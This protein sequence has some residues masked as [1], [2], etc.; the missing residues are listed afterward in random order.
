MRHYM[1]PATFTGA[2]AVMTV[3]MGG[4]STEAR[5]I[6]ASGPPDGSPAAAKPAIQIT[7][8]DVGIIVLGIQNNGTFGD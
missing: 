1:R 2:W 8:P 5:S 3:L 7:Q 4:P 6:V